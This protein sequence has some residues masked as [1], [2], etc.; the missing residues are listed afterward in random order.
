MRAW[1][2]RL[3]AV[4]AWGLAMP[5]PGAEKPDSRTERGLHSLRENPI[6]LL[7]ADEA[8][9]QAARREGLSLPA[10]RTLQRRDLL[11]RIFPHLIFPDSAV[12][13]MAL[14]EEFISSQ[15]PE[16]RESAQAMAWSRYAALAAK[17]PDSLLPPWESLAPFLQSLEM[18]A[19]PACRAKLLVKS[20]PGTFREVCLDIP[21]ADT[22]QAAD[23]SQADGPGP[24]K[25]PGEALPWSPA[26]LQIPSSPPG[27]CLVLA[28]DGKQCQV[29]VEDF[30]SRTGN[31]RIP[32]QGALAEGRADMLRALLEEDF[33]Q[34]G[35]RALVRKTEVSKR[36][37]AVPDWKTPVRFRAASDTNRLESDENHWLLAYLEDLPE[38]LYPLRDSSAVFTSP[39]RRKTRYGYFRIQF[40]RRESHMAHVAGGL[41]QEAEALARALGRERG[42]LEKNAK[43][44][45]ARWDALFRHPDT[46]AYSLWLASSP[47][48]DT[49]AFRS[50]QVLSTGVLND[51]DSIAWKYSLGKRLDTL[52]GPFP[53]A[54]G[55]VLLRLRGKAKG[56][57]KIPFDSAQESIRVQMARSL[58]LGSA[59]GLLQ[60]QGLADAEPAGESLLDVP[61]PRFKDKDELIRAVARLQYGPGGAGKSH[62]EA[63]ARSPQRLLED[64]YR[65]HKQEKDRAEWVRSLRITAEAER[66]SIGL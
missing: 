10:G 64:M 60:D 56:E 23:A 57:G 35:S 48:T 4:A 16:Q 58:V 30:N 8:Y 46:L 61:L 63:L 17:V 59:L 33:R 13:R 29:T 53:T 45:Y 65:I 66:L 21:R 62:L 32:A 14:A 11:A 1:M 42:I 5:C 18:Q 3:A 51:I 49:A 52:L 41:L 6:P 54:Y 15:C 47:A 24:E 27:A 50:V 2:V 20:S 12:Q 22:S 25:A 37:S 26:C 55:T 43:L 19:I 7:R 40:D 44:F 38:E 34:R 31:Y 39:I 9:V 36:G 28:K